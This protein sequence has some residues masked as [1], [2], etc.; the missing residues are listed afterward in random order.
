MYNSEELVCLRQIYH[1]I[2]YIYSTICSHQLS[3]CACSS[4]CCTP[5]SPDARCSACDK[6]ACIILMLVTLVAIYL[7]SLWSSR[8]QS[9][10]VELLMHNRTTASNV[11]IAI[12]IL[13]YQSINQSI[14]GFVCIMCP[15]ST[16]QVI[17]EVI[18]GLYCWYL[19]ELHTLVHLARLSSSS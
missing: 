8:W 7:S 6:P 19:L 11:P 14:N 17:N 2:I 18:V 4:Q 16:I 3:N 13:V 5:H 10:T 12:C 9:S 1:T 15:C